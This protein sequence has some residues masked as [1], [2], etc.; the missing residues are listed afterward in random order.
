MTDDGRMSEIHSST[1]LVRTLDHA[2]NERRA[3]SGTAL[4]IVSLESQSIINDS[5]G[6]GTGNR[7]AETVER[8]LLQMFSTEDI[9]ARVA[10]DDFAILIADLGGALA[11][12]RTARRV[13]EV[14]SRPIARQDGASVPEVCLGMVLASGS[15]R[16]AIDMMRDA[17]AALRRARSKNSG[18][19]QIFDESQ[20]NEMIERS[21]MHQSIVRALEHDEF[22]LHYQPIVLLDTGQPDAVEG[23]LR[24]NDPTGSTIAPGAVIAAAE[25]SHLINRIGTWVLNDACRQAFEW[26]HADTEVA[27]PVVHV[28]VSPRQLVSSPIVEIVAQAL[29]AYGTAPE[30]ICLEV[31]ESTMMEEVAVPILTEL[32]QLGVGLSIDDFGTG[33]SSLD[34]LCRLPIDSLKLD[35]IFVA[36]AATSDKSAAIARAVLA[37]AHALDL[38]VIAEGIETTTQLDQMRDLGYHRGQGFLFS[39]PQ[40]VADLE[41][42]TGWSS[43]RRSVVGSVLPPTDQNHPK[44]IRLGSIQ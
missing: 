19:Y 41:S 20:R 40:S 29:E 21:T 8:R 35:R 36:D 2:L 6:R 44:V 37:M 14:L 32:K 1:E 11:A 10:E 30:A 24:W 28:N 3:S 7:H 31:T 38:S 25:R 34:R 15:Q 33:Y 12:H 27:P 9:V 43:T 5:L 4:I 18:A 42:L 16:N 23:L 22:V 39:K 13:I 17:K 26:W